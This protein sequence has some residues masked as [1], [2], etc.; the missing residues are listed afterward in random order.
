MLSPQRLVALA[1][2]DA[3]LS[4]APPEPANVAPAR[5]NLPAPRGLKR[6]QLNLLDS[7]A[8]QQVICQRPL[9]P[10]DHMTI[11]DAR[12]GTVEITKEKVSNWATVKLAA[13]D[14][15]NNASATVSNV[16]AQDP[17]FAFKEAAVL[18][19]TQVFNGLPDSLTSVA[20]Q[21]FLPMVRVVSLGLDLKKASEIWK[22][23]DA[24]KMDLAIAG[25]HLATDIA[26]VGGA[27]GLVFP[28][29]GHGIAFGLTAIALM[30]DMA[31]YGYHIMKFFHDRGFALPPPDQ[32]PNS[33]QIVA[34][35]N[36]SK[37]AAVK[38]DRTV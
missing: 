36:N 14:F 32:D 1:A 13:R 6:D 23:K 8:V 17:A 25:A 15:T 19:Q 37:T 3:S 5:S 31:A 29:F 34:R 35:G 2:S 26:G 4:A 27:V 33:G 20:S 18:V 7:A 21:G 12:G 30:G 9:Q 10:G 11:T 24:E 16:V 22:D 28:V 38:M